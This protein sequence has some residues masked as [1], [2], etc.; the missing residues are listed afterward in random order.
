MGCGAGSSQGTHEEDRMTD[1]TAGKGRYAPVN[2][3]KMYYEIHGAAG[4]GLPPLVL[5]HGGGSTIETSFAALLPDLARTRQV[6][7][8]EQQGHGH[9]ADIDRPF[10]FEQ[11][12][13]D[14]AALLRHLRVERAD[15][16]GFSNGG[17]AA[18]QIAIR[19]P[20]LVRKLVVA[21]AMFRRDGL[22]P[23]LLEGLARATP[24]D[25]PADLRE[26]YL[27]TSPHPEQLPAF[28]ARCTRRMLDFQDWS[29]EVIRAIEAPTLLVIGDADVIRPEHAV[30]MFRLLPHAQLA[31]LPGT[32][33]AALMGRADLLLAAIPQFLDAPMPAPR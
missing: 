13:D 31:V 27:R 28:V 4:G 5:L 24:E 22:V 20:Q 29:P 9:T 10:S 26:A 1:R 18:L 33:H 14:T 11:T 25:M 23:G 17:S 15:F 3:L 21:S 12:A 30:E 16:F 2:G 19:H 8:F 6:I 7:A 32:D